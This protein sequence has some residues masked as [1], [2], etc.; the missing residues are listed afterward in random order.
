MPFFCSSLSLP[1]SYRLY[2]LNTPSG[3]QFAMSDICLLRNIQMR[4][5]SI[6]L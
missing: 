5:E 6:K 3:R 4:K 1:L 2:D